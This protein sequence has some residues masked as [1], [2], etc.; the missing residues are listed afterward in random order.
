MKRPITP[1]RAIWFALAFLFLCAACG[2]CLWLA[3]PSLAYQGYKYESGKD[4][5]SNQARQ[6]Q[7]T[8]PPPAGDDVE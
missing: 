5:Q 3:V 4:G 7:N 6:H 1:G 8:R 2:G